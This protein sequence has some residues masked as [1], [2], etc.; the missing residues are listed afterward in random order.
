MLVTLKKNISPK[1]SDMELRAG[2]VVKVLHPVTALKKLNKIADYALGENLIIVTA[3]SPHAE[4][5]LGGHD[6]HK[7]RTEGSVEQRRDVLR[8]YVSFA[9]GDLY[10]YSILLWDDE[11]EEVDETECP[12]C[13]RSLMDEDGNLMDKCHSCYAMD[14][15]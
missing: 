12:E 10:H 1:Y 11:Y 8:I 5:P 3:T 13:E 9:V 14:F 4:Y 6:Y 15:A 7:E 2:D